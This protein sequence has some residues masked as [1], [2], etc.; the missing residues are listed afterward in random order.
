M[1]RASPPAQCRC[2][3]GAKLPNRRVF[4]L[5]GARVVWTFAMTEVRGT[6]SRVR[7][8]PAR[9]CSFTNARLTLSHGHSF[10]KNYYVLR[11]EYREVGDN[12]SAQCCRR[13]VSLAG[14]GSSALCELHGERR[15]GGRLVNAP[16]HAQRR[17]RFPAIS[18][19]RGALFPSPVARTEKSCTAAAT[20][21]LTRFCSLKRGHQDI[22]KDAVAL[23]RPPIKPRVLIV[24]RIR[25][26]FFLPFGRCAAMAWRLEWKRHARRVVVDRNM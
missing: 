6:P 7:F 18:H 20:K 19:G 12:S 8:F 5:L 21:K 3:D 2:S 10:F 1:P 25:L 23:P 24:G 13:P 16:A 22:A 11:R 4:A 9:Y 17:S 26:P 14:A 15:G